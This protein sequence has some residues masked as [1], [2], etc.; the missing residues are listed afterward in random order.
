LKLPYSLEGKVSRVDDE[1]I[2]IE[3]GGIGFFLFCSKS[4]LK[5]ASS[6]EAIK[7]L[8][9]LHVTESGPS[10]FAF[11]D[12][13]EKQL[14]LLLLKVRGVGAKL[15]ITIIRSL[16]FREIIHS[17]ASD[18]SAVLCQVPEVGKKTA[19]RLCFELKQ[20]IEKASFSVLSDMVSTDSGEKVQLVYDALDG[21]GFKRGESRQAV[22]GVIERIGSIPASTEELLRQALTELQRN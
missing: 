4:V 9:F 16:E 11:M 15:A 18:R 1:G 19:E 3:V 12:E 10:L 5:E 8:T 6:F 20:S 13:D 17:I 7:V 2:G 21:L 14:F 22:A